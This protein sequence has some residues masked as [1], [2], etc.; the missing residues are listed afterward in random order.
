MIKSHKNLPMVSL[1]A[2]FDVVLTKTKT[3][4]DNGLFSTVLLMPTGLK[5]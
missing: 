4:K 3:E 2:C 5:I 1:A